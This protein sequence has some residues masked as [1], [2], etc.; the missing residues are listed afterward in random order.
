MA[1][2]SNYS[3]IS[4]LF[5]SGTQKE[6][7][8]PFSS[9]AT[10][11]SLFPEKE[12]SQGFFSSLISNAKD[13]LFQKP[14]K[15][16]GVLDLPKF[17]TEA[18]GGVAGSIKKAGDSLEQ[19]YEDIFNPQK[20]K[21]DVAISA[22]HTILDTVGAVFSPISSSL[23]AAGRVEGI[24]GDAAT[25]VNNVF[26]T[27][28]SIGG[29]TVSSVV[30]AGLNK[31][32]VSQETK[33]KIRP[34]MQ[35]LGSLVGEIALGKFGG[36]ALLAKKTEAVT[37]TKQI[38]EVVKSDTTSKTAE[39]IRQKINFNKDLP[40]ET[41]NKIRGIGVDELRFDKDGNI[42]VYRD[43]APVPGMT[44]GY[45]LTKKA[46]Q[47]PYVV[48]K[49]DIIANF[50]SEK[51]VDLYKTGFANEPK[52][53]RD[54]NIDALKKFQNLESEVLVRN[55]KADIAQSLPGQPIEGTV[56]KPSKQ[57]TEISE[58]LKENGVDPAPADLAQYG[59]VENFMQYQK[60]LFDELY[61]RDSE[62]ARKI[63]LGEEYATGGLKNETVFSY[64]KERAKAEG[65]TALALRLAE[66]PVARASSIKGQDIKSL[67]VDIGTDA[68]KAISSINE[69][70]KAKVLGNKE[71]SDVVKKET[72][73][74]EK[75]EPVAEKT[76]EEF[77]NSLEC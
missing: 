28:G 49:N 64:M 34:L 66:S 40:E 5:D 8:T 21:G 71:F 69:A 31:F 39:D 2:F 3:S 77:I 42:T 17:T 19:T 37:R 65:D 13:A 32:N 16:I 20:T 29:D 9:Y 30:D 22:G 12:K 1:D 26:A 18:A 43:S 57:A 52:T 74:L 14:E 38:E 41:V 36:E 61:A 4:G 25:V 55:P 35:E 27:A 59:T 67:D 68:V 75:I 76:W 11:S 63:A 45:S 62:L 46:G 56:L 58:Y 44:Q 6:S 23:S 15:T 24:T 72:K 48:N 51:V 10:I 60:K 33:D 53:I 54:A 70:R 73:N 7:K 47:E 50:S